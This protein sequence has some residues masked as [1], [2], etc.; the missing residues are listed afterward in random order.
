MGV[1]IRPQGLKGEV[2]VRLFNASSPLWA[3]GRSFRAVRS[4][5]VEYGLTIEELGT[6]GRA[7][8][9]RFR[10]VDGRDAA[11]RLVGTEL[12]VDRSA[13]PAIA[14]DEVYV[15]DLI[16]LAVRD[17]KG[18]PLGR[19]ESIEEGGKKDFLVIEEG[20][21]REMVPLDPGVLVAVDVAG[22]WLQ[23]GIDLPFEAGD[24]L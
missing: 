8:I 19:V 24:D 16:G 10:G 21:R 14:E 4:D 15:A 9:L 3:V 5:G 1:V 11:E 13:L 20:G 2:A 22:G 12:W 23:V 17:S 6:G 18:R 7:A